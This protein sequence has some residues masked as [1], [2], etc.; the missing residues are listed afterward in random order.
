MPT[1]PAAAV[2]WFRTAVT[3][4]TASAAAFITRTATTPTTT[5]R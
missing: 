3:Q 2:K 1:A 4:T 5:V